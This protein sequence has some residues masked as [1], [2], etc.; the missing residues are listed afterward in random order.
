MTVVAC[1]GKMP[2]RMQKYINKDKP[3]G[4]FI[5][6][7]Q[8]LCPFQFLRYDTR[9]QNENTTTPPIY[10]LYFICCIGDYKTIV[11]EQLA[12]VRKNGLFHRTH[13]IFCF[14][15]QYEQDILDV[16]Q[17]YMSKLKIISTTEN[18][19][20]KYALSNFRKH[21]PSPS[22]YYLYYFHTKGVSRKQDVFHERRRNLDY[23]ILEQYDVCLFWLNQKYD[24]VGTTL[25]QFPSLHF[26]GNFWWA[27]SSHLD[28]LSKQ[29]I[30]DSYLAPEMYICSNPKGKYISVC[31]ETNHSKREEL[32]KKTREQILRES[33]SAPI[34]NVAC[35]NMRF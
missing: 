10:G 14:I 33:T 24:A 1:S 19:Y 13:T 9:I 18:L 20:E 17:P 26:S 12:S 25:S 32:S 23:F 2:I 22:P 8:E 5:P 15:C 21:I 3:Y 7:E 28:R 6:T 27:K 31:Q 34:R 11:A 16:L 29:A 30:G 4:T 35:R